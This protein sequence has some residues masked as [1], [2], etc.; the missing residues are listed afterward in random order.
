M[1]RRGGLH[2]DDEDR[3]GPPLSAGAS[4]ATKTAAG[5]GLEMTTRTRGHRNVS[6]LEQHQEE[7]VRL[8][9]L[10]GD[11]NG[12]LSAS[13]SS[14]LL[15][16]SRDGRYYDDGVTPLP[17]PE[18][19]SRN[20]TLMSALL[21]AVHGAGLACLSVAVSKFGSVGA[22]QG[23]ILYLSYTSCAVVG[24]ASYVTKTLGSKRTI[25]LGMALFC[26]YVGCFYWVAA[27]SSA[28][29][30]TE[31][32]SSTADF[33]AWTGAALGGVG[34]AFLW[35]AQ[36]VYLCEASEEYAMVSY[37]R[38]D[39]ETSNAM[40]A[41]HFAFWLLAEETAMEVLS[42]ILIRGW[43]ISWIILFALYAIVAVAATV[44]T[45]ICVK[46]YRHPTITTTTA[47]TITSNWQQQLGQQY[48]PSNES[49]W[50]KL[51]AVFRLLIT[52]PKMK[53]MIGLNAAFGFAGAFLNS[54]VSGE[55]V[56][57]ALQDD[58]SS[59]VGLLVA[60]HGS[61]AAIGSL[62]FARLSPYIGKGPILMFGAISFSCVAFP[63]LV[64]P[65]IQSW[66]WPL[67]VLVYGVEGV[68]RAT[69]EGTLKA[70][71]GDY[72]A[73]EKEGA[74]ANI[75]L[76][77]GL[78]SSIAYV[79][80]FTMTCSTPSTYCIRYRDGSLHDLLSYGSLVVVT[81]V[82][83]VFGFWRASYLFDR[84]VGGGTEELNRYRA[85]TAA[86]Y[87]GRTVQHSTVVDKSG[88]RG[89]TYESLETATKVNADDENGNGNV[90]YTSGGDL[91]EII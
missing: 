2:E 19:V 56:P 4:A 47:T 87:R 59:W 39:W 37:E 11:E 78:A 33:A 10:A 28:S 51:T 5:V 76:Q 34:A 36:G 85:R 23:G 61:V 63:F 16:R 80:S 58:R 62:A 66:T 65:D 81:G 54:F 70:Q 91:P 71:F 30:D 50:Y 7:K 31:T 67:L 27:S 74:F 69:F 18:S 64:R 15:P 9:L 14:D 26:A 75:I 1:P 55:V 3:D 25:V 20:F 35:T 89:R 21:G 48:T 12:S 90:G 29:A 13:T 53:Y 17:S 8:A 24:L 86:E 43:G 88:F 52:D 45:A 73:Y 44:A 72:F 41:G 46:E 68:G 60:I 32:S 82:V 6:T 40:M 57:V 79:L 49:P 38:I 42:T 84:G 77:N 83:A 22:Y